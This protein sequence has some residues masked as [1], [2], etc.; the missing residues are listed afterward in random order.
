MLVKTKYFGEIELDDEKVITFDQGI[1]GFEDYKRYALIYNSE[2]ER[3]PAISWLQS[4]DEETLAL[5]VMIPTLV[6]ED[7]NPEVEDGVLEPI[8]EWTEDD[9][10]ILVTVTV[11]SDIKAMT[12]NMKA[13]FIINTSNMK[14]CQVVVE[15]KDYEIRYPIYDILT[16]ISK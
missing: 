7:Y 11:P 14:G 5:P 1:F 16:G 9:I 13:P 8:G 15:N 10:S 6:K 4:I 12:S 2:S 3:R